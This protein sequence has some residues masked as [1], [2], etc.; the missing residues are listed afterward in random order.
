M[1]QKGA[2]QKPKPEIA[3]SSFNKYVVEDD[4]PKSFNPF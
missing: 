1:I 4:E 2:E 3:I